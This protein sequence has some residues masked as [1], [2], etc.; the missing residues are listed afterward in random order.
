MQR[1]K[2]I[3][4]LDLDYVI[5]WRDQDWSDQTG[6]HGQHSYT[7]QTIRV[8]RSTQQI[9]ANTLMHEILHAV[10]D[11]MSLSDESSEEDFVSRLATGLCAVWRDNPKVW[12]WWQKQICTPKTRRARVRR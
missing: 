5:E 1:P 4:I 2:K 8:Q 11:G 9:E 3:K 7:S 12:A 6:S 10:A